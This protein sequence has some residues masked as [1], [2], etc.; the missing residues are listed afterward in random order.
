MV[1]RPRELDVA[2]LVGAPGV[3]DADVGPQR[4]HGEVGLAAVG[5]DDGAEARGPRPA[6]EPRAARV[7]RN[8][9]PMTRRAARRPASTRRA[10]GRRPRRPRRR[11]RSRARH[12]GDPRPD[13][14]RGDRAQRAR[15]EQQ[16][17]LERAGERDQVEV[18]LAGERARRRD[19]LAAQ[20]GAREARPSSRRRRAR[21][22]RPSVPT[23][24]VEPRL[25][26]LEERPQALARLGLGERLDRR[27]ALDREA[28][29]EAPGRSR[30]S[31]SA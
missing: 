2:V 20:D 31:G 1:G 21:R 17:D 27:R 7:G 3:D 13:V 5:V 11:G 19:R 23:L 24:T 26:L 10:R 4:R 6:A 22:G 14:R 25:A 9:I 30:R 18:A 15:R 29:R 12:R 8:G 28:L 16:L